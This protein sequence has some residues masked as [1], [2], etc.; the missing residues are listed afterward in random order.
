MLHEVIVGVI[1][2]GVSSKV[3]QD[4]LGAG[5]YGTNSELGITR[6]SRRS[7]DPV[8]PSDAV[9]VRP[10]NLSASVIHVLTRGP[11]ASEVGV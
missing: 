1:L 3:L 10:A 7:E 4:I 11:A 9:A 2:P 6:N 5:V 8:V